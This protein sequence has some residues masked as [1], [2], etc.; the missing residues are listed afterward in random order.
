MSSSGFY[1]A[2][3]SPDNKAHLSRAAMIFVRLEREAKNAAPLCPQHGFIDPLSRITFSLRIRR[4]RLP[5]FLRI[6]VSSETELQPNI[7]PNEEI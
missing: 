4:K 3:P 7:H 2:A 6:A 5:T 1:H